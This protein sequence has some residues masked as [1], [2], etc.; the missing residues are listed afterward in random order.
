MAPLFV[1]LV[2]VVGLLVVWRVAGGGDGTDPARDSAVEG[3]AHVHGLG[4]DPG[5]GTLYVATHHGV[6]RL[7]ASGEAERV[8][9]VQ[10]TM[11]F[12]VAG[13]G[14]FL[15]SGH[16]DQAGIEDG[17]PPL[18][19]LI[20]SIDGARTWQAVSLSGEVD[21]HALAFAHDQVYGWDSSSGRLMVSTDEQDWD[22]RATLQLFSIAVD[23]ADGDHVVATTPDGLS[24]STDGGRSWQRVDGAPQVVL[25]AWDAGRGIWGVGPSGA[26]VHATSVEGPW[27]EVA[28]LPGSPQA[29]LASGDTLYAAVADQAGVAGIY[30]STDGGGSWQTRYRDGQ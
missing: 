19:G 6:F 25:V 20:E 9:P 13:A 21:F 12:T 11:G 29:L 22:T 10:D 27:D 17:Q 23:P 30:E 14:H 3:V 4:V 15:G 8:G 18:L 26:V 16:P 5:D 28:A 2:L 1:A 24:S 7:P